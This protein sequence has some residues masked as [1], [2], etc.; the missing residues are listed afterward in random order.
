[1][2]WPGSA[3]CPLADTSETRTVDLHM[4]PS[5]HKY[6]FEQTED[7]DSTHANESQSIDSIMADLSI[8]NPNKAHIPAIVQEHT[9]GLH[10]LLSTLTTH[11]LDSISMDRI[12]FYY[13][14]TLRADACVCSWSSLDLKLYVNVLVFHQQ[15]GI[16]QEE[17]DGMIVRRSR[18]IWRYWLQRVC[19]ALAK[20]SSSTLASDKTENDSR[21]PQE[22]KQ[23]ELSNENDANHQLA[24]GLY[25]NQIR[26]RFRAL[27]QQLSL[28]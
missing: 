22:S 3:G 9:R 15:Q 12:V 10:F 5:W 24:T 1:M 27:A 21:M 4:L 23:S 19:M 20:K 16:S 28:Q 14:P 26:T 7:N 25:N 18:R 2:F 11:V 8:N 13:M 6:K 17:H